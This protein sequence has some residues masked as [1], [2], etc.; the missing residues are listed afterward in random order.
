MKG[1]LLV[2]T[3]WSWCTTGT[4]CNFRFNM[5]TARCTSNYPGSSIWWWKYRL[6]GV[7]RVLPAHSFIIPRTWICTWQDLSIRQNR[8]R[9]RLDWCQGWWRLFN[10]KGRFNN[11]KPQTELFFWV[12]ESCGNALDGQQGH[13]MRCLTQYVNVRRVIMSPKEISIAA[14]DQNNQGSKTGDLLQ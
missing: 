14:V 12:I 6:Y 9:N 5:G 7:I 13:P 3:R 11:P 1:E 4:N 2:E 8:S 10:R